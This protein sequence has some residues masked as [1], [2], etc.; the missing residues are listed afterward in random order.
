MNEFVPILHFYRIV[1]FWWVVLLS[2]LLGG[3]AGYV[4]YRSG[5]PLYEATATFYVTIDFD[6]VEGGPLSQY[7]EDL[8]LSVMQQVLYYS[9]EVQEKIIA[10]PEFAEA[11]FTQESWIDSIILEREHAFWKIRVR[12]HSPEA[13]QSLVNLWAELGYSHL[14]SLKEAGDIPDYIILEPP[15]PAELPQ[16]PTSYGMNPL[17][18]AG[19]TIGL[20]A[21]I[22]LSNAL[23]ERSR[24][25][26]RSKTVGEPA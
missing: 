10:S 16:D 13:A 11:S 14:V 21:G 9:P 4:I 15:V 24:G 7:D 25:A 6:R 26:D 17:I 12:H 23:A 8:A 22:F 18:L 20:I 3:A 19:S 1:R 5:A 2:I